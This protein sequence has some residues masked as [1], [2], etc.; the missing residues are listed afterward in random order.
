MTK[1]QQ[2]QKH[3]LYALWHMTSAITGHCNART[4]RTGEDNHL[5]TPDE[6]RDDAMKTAKRHIELIDEI[7]GANWGNKE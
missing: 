1:D 5:L 7:I 4:V 3:S 6:L 2:I